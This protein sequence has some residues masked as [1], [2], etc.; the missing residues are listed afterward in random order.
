MLGGCAS[1]PNGPTMTEP[2]AYQAHLTAIADI[3]SFVLRGR[4]GVLTETK[5]FSGA[6][7]WH[8]H[9]NG[10]DIDFYSPLGTQLGHISND[11][12]GVTLTTSEQKTV[13]ADSVE[14]LTEQTIGWRLPLAGLNDWALGRPT[15]SAIEAQHWDESGRLATLRQDGWDIE[16]SQYRDQ[17]GK[18][19][20]GKIVLKSPK[21]DIKL[22]VENWQ[23]GTL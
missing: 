2:E 13:R 16:F 11:A 12:E 6:M 21:L 7:R 1:L 18:S 5:G 4:I 20:P 9:E 19:L 10:D 15:T 3:D 14:T 17:D 8:H 23:I 22:V